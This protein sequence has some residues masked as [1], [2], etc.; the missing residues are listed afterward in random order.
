MGSCY[1]LLMRIYSRSALREFWVNHADAEQSLIAWFAEAKKSHWKE[2]TDILNQYS[3][4]RI[5]GKNRAVFNIMGNSY[6][7]VVSIRYDKGLVY[8][9]FIGTH[10]DYDKINALTI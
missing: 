8:I 9:R 6:R 5:I 10:A 1:G 7:L 3:N 4:A 2:P